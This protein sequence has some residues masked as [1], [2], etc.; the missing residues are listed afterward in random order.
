VSNWVREYGLWEALARIGGDRVRSPS[1]EFEQFRVI[2]EIASHNAG[3][4]I[5]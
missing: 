2:A 3:G 4:W 1:V 5:G